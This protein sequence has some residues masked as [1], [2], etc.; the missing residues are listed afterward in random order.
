[1][2][3][4]AAQK[5]AALQHLGYPFVEWSLNFLNNRL[6]V[7]ASL[8][9]SAELESQIISF[10]ETLTDVDASRQS[11]LNSIA[12]Q[13][14][15]GSSGNAY[16]RSQAIAE[17]NNEYNYFRNRLSSS[18]DMPTYDISNNSSAS[19]GLIVQG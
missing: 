17:Y 19:I 14:I 2:S 3:L 13:Q 10:I 12:G 8:S 1:M 9:L 11:Y 18:L 4:T 6:S 15:T 16:Y 5:V 7:I